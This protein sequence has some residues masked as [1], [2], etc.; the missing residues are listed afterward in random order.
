MHAKVFGSPPALFPVLKSVRFLPMNPLLDVIL[1]NNLLFDAVGVIGPGLVG[2]AAV[3][4][5]RRVALWGYERW[6]HARNR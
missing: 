1:N 3:K 5:A 4:L 2:L 6:L